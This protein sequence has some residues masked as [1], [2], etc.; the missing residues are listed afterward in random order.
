MEN[1]AIR[2]NNFIEENINQDLASGRFDHVKTRVP[3]EPNGYLHIGHAKA[4]CVDFGI[5][6]LH[7]VIGAKA[8]GVNGKWNFENVFEP[9]DSRRLKFE[10]KD[11]E[12]DEINGS[13]EENE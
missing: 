9:I 13:T 5:A 3:P 8:K 11:N 10:P 4:L 2:A 6:K 12:E 1:E 7:F